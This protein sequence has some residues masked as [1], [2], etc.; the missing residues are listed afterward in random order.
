MLSCTVLNGCGYSM[1]STFTVDG[2]FINHI[3]R[4]ADEPKYKRIVEKY[5]AV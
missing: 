4:F 2:K 5:F 1:V 3:A